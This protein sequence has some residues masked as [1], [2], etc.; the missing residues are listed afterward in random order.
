MAKLNYNRPS[1]KKAKEHNK[2]DLW[3]PIPNPKI[4]K[5]GKY[6]GKHISVIPI[7]YLEWLVSIT[8]DDS[9]ALIYC[10]EIAN[11]KSKP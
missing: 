11:R 9:F 2:L 4:L 7:D 1:I 3:T 5:F 6:K 8:P 10:K